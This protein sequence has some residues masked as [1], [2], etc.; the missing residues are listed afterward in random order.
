MSTKSA[1]RPNQSQVNRNK[2]GR[3]PDWYWSLKSCYNSRATANST[4]QNHS[5]AQSEK[6]LCAGDRIGDGVLLFDDNRSA[7]NY[8]R[9]RKEE[10]GGGLQTPPPFKAAS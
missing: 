3:L 10:V 4:L 1:S 5:L 8:C 9:N 6:L 2:A 7:G